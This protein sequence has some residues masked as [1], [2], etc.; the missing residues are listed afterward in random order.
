MSP[1]ARQFLIALS[2]VATG[3]SGGVAAAASK[4]SMGGEV[5]TYVEWV[6]ILCPTLSSFITTFLS[7]PKDA[8]EKDARTRDGDPQEKE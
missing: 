8:R 4:D 3:F 2:I 7:A 6:T 5:I 1:S